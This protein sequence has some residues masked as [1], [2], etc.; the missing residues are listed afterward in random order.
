MW[1]KHIIFFGQ[2]N[3]TIYLPFWADESFSMYHVAL[4]VENKMEHVSPHGLDDLYRQ[5]V[6]STISYELSESV[7]KNVFS[8]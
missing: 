2:V 5:H 1:T 6:N 8:K 4:R 3:F 7:H